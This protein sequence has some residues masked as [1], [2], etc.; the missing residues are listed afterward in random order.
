MVLIIDG[1]NLIILLFLLIC[2][3]AFFCYQK[4][5]ILA[6]PTIGVSALFL[7]GFNINLDGLNIVL[8]LILI[9]FMF[10]S[11]IENYDAYKK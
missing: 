6:L 1:S 11:A 3:N 4:I 9:I 8:S 10:G 2:L 7:I 5:P